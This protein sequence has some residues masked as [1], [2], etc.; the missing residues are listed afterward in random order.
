EAY[1]KHQNLC[2]AVRFYVNQLFGEEGLVVVDAD[3]RQMKSLFTGVIEDDLF[4]HTAKQKVDHTDQQLETQGYSTQ[5]HAR[6]INFFYLEDQ[7]RGRIERTKEGFEVVDTDL[8][9]SEEEMKGLIKSDP[10]K[11]SPNVI[12]RPLY[13]EIV[14]PNLAYFGGP[15]EVIYWLQLK[16]VFDN[17]KV[18]F[19]ILMPRNFAMV[20]DGPTARKFEKTGLS[21]EELFEPKNYLF[22]N[23]VAKN[24]NHDLS[25]TK[26]LK[27]V[28]NLFDQIKKRALEIDPTLG[29]LV[30]AETKRGTKSFEKIEQ[31]LLKAEKRHHSDKLRQI[32]DV[33]DALFPGGGLQERSDNFLNFY[34]Q[35]SEFIKKLLN[36]FDPFDFQFNL[37]SYP[38]A[39]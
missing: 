12:L 10:E 1:L 35:D 15:A 14:L 22:N 25:L 16:G 27:T 18:P 31:K 29:P 23:W 38:Y 7:I 6:D 13:Q 39:K 17:F 19:P 24:T 5:V 21:D 28:S 30:E 4:K 9:F 32:E 33:K 26:E 36:V 37:L 34:Q 2:D 8:K 20:L 3:N 11:F